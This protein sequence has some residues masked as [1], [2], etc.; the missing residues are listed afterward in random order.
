MTLSHG[1]EASK[2]DD[3]HSY[4]YSY[5]CDGFDTVNGDNKQQ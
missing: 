3:N 4:S 5:S 1:Y 2:W